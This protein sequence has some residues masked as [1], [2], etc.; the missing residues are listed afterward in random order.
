MSTDLL[1]P[2][3]ASSEYIINESD[4]ALNT[5]FGDVS[6]GVITTA[7]SGDNTLMLT[8]S[9]CSYQYNN[10]DYQKKQDRIMAAR[11]ALIAMQNGNQLKAVMIYGLL[12]VMV[13]FI[14]YKLF[15]SHWTIFGYV[16]SVAAFALVAIAITGLIFTPKKS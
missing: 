1:C 9:S 7:I 16:F 12:G 13:G 15:V 4:I 14:A 8:C 3:C 2:K 6:Q 11:L 10:G 5:L